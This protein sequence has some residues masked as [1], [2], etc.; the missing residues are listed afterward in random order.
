M[1]QNLFFQNEMPQEIELRDAL[2]ALAI[3]EAVASE[4]ASLFLEGVRTQSRHT[5]FPEVSARVQ[6]SSSVFEYKYDCQS[7]KSPSYFS[8]LSAHEN[9]MMRILCQVLQHLDG[10]WSSRRVVETRGSIQASCEYTRA[11]CTEV[12]CKHLI[13]IGLFQ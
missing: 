6:H 2:D 10:S 12:P 5:S 8:S 11:T 1:P 9:V 3:S 4:T 13:S 7:M